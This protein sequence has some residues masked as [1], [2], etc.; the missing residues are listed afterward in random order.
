MDSAR[1]LR[2]LVVSNM[3]PTPETPAFGTFVRDQ[4]QALRATGAV[5]VD[6]FTFDEFTYIVV[7]VMLA[8]LG[9]GEL[10]VDHFLLKKYA[11]EKK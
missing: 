4:V 3:Y 6:L 9:P 11:P 2:V 8:V 1:R 10:S 5:D 7:M